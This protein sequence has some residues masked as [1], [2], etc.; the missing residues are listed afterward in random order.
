MLLT[1]KFYSICELYH[2]TLKEIFKNLQR[3]NRSVLVKKILT[4]RIRLCELP[5][6]P[7][8]WFSAF[9]VSLA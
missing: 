2:N 6:S 5:P 4:C 1:G 9:A 7:L 8:F 3:R